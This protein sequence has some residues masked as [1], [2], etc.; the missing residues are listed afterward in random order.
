M[1]ICYFGISDSQAI[2]EAFALVLSD[3][4]P[5]DEWLTCR[6]SIRGEHAKEWL[7]PVF[8]PGGSLGSKAIF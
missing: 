7:F 4:L 5:S 3:S 1:E 8:P 6:D 2:V